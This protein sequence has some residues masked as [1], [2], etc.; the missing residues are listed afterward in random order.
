M[1]TGSPADQVL[2]GSRPPA[3]LFDRENTSLGHYLM[4]RS[5][6]IGRGREV[7][8]VRDL[9]RRDDVPLVTLTGPGGVGKTRLALQVV[10]DA[11]DEFADGVRFVELASV[12]DPD[13]VLPTIASAL[14]LNDRGNQPQIE[15]LV[16]HLRQKRLLLALDNLEQVVDVAPRIADLLVQCRQLKV[17][18][19][20]RVTLRL[21]EEHDIPVDPLPV[22]D[23]VHLFVTRAQAANPA[24][25]LTEENAATITAICKRLDGLPLAV[26][27]AAAR[28]RV[29][30][31]AALLAR[32]EHALPL[33]T[34]GALD[35]P[36]RLR[37]M[38][39]A[40]AW[41]FDLLNST[42]Q[43]L[44]ARLSVFMGGFVLSSAETL[45]SI[46]SEISPSF[47]SI[48]SHSMLDN[49]LGLVE[50]NL[51]R[52]VG[53]PDGEEPRYQMLETIREFG[54]EQ[55][56]E[57]G[58]ESVVRAAH[59][60]HVTEMIE[61]LTVR[62]F[63]PEFAHVLDRMEMEQDNARSALTW[64]EET[65]AHEM[66]LRLAR[67]MSDFWMLRGHLREGRRWLELF[68]AHSDPAPSVTRAGALTSIGWLTNFQGDITTAESWFLESI[69]TA[70]TVDNGWLEAVSFLG[71]ATI[72]Q[73]RGDLGR[74]ENLAE[75]GVKRF[76][77][78]EQ[79]A[80]SGALWLSLAYLDRGQ[81]AVL[82]R[83][84]AVAAH[85]LDLAERR[86]RTLRFTWALSDTLR[87]RGDLAR[88]QGDYQR[89]LAAYREAVNLW[90]DHGDLRLLTDALTGIA[91]VAALT[92]QS[93]TAARLFGAA[94]THRLRV[95][96]GVE[97]WDHPAYERGV[98]AARAALSSEAFAGAWAAGEALS[99]KA[100]IAEALDVA[101]PTDF[102]P[103]GARGDFNLT[104]R[105]V[106]VLRHLAHGHSNREIAEALFIS[107]RTVEGHV[108]NLLAKLR[109][110]SRTAATA[111]AVRHGFDEPDRTE[112]SD[113][114]RP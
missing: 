89:A 84:V 14:G 17:L 56:K 37:T 106:D 4:R 76:E 96:V 62:I 105:E 16:M 111:F 2:P 19:T 94:A 32:L 57:R 40:I 51:L 82:Q 69:D 12:R 1:G 49:I 9:L 41:S 43:V 24:F 31:P 42:E 28:V 52:L 46:L 64:A 54:R 90:T 44:L 33:L 27:L 5:P 83:D 70:R 75:A 79:D 80:E 13:L 87:A 92:S 113:V 98:D 58:E 63:S 29:L 23:A 59:A 109:L 103:T 22:S 68:L 81:I 100:F 66:G 15:Q 35:R 20:S 102:T 47:R 3:L 11:A 93:E 61:Q 112:H 108:T 99:L 104:S 60:R 67:A 10:S 55:L 36:D 21:S 50:N 7:N 18:A 30:P 72:A 8:A 110:D 91:G 114:P 25:T 74:A 73:Q 95:G 101:V 26:E 45:T 53:S 77:S 97:G 48:S 107:T 71:L 88:D 34:G 78:L 85:Y 65:G 86:L 6:L 38:R 39:R